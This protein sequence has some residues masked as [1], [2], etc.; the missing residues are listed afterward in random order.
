MQ[1]TRTTTTNTEQ[2][3]LPTAS[4]QAATSAGAP[5]T[6][7]PSVASTVVNLS[8]EARQHLA[9]ELQNSLASQPGTDSSQAQV[10]ARQRKL[11]EKLLKRTALLEMDVFSE[12]REK[13]KAQLQR[14]VTLPPAQRQAA[15][16]QLLQRQQDARPSVPT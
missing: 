5:A 6:V 14:K 9:E 16:D 10:Q 2:L 4:D 1:I 7:A 13:V 3:A 8:G 12:M 15:D 11:M